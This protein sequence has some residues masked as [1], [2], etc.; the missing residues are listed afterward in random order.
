[1]EFLGLLSTGKGTWGQ[2]VGLIEK[3][4]WEKI[5]VIGPSYAEKF[6]MPGKKVNFIKA[7]FDKPLQDLIKDFKEKLSG[8]FEGM[9]V[10]LSLASGSGR[11]HMAL[12]S[13]LI[14]IP[15]GIKFTALTKDGIVY[16]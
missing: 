11:E 9:E 1:M 16:F 14:Q 6:S 13:A 4:D 15:L 2:I 3:G 7:D 10:A 8:K 5:V 12:M